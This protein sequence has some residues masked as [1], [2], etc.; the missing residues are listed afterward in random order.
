MDRR[1]KK[2]IA[3]YLRQQEQIAS[4]AISKLDMRNWFDLWHTHVDWKSKAT[5]ARP[6]V[7]RL[8]YR[9]L[10]Q[11]EERAAIRSDPI[12]LWATLCEDTG[13]NAIY[14]HSENPNGSPYPY[15]FDGVLWDV[16]APHE[17]QGVVEHTHE[18]GC[19]RYETQVVYLIRKRAQ[20]SAQPDRREDAAPG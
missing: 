16:Q 4:A 20:Q 13:Q 2:R 9:L 6:Q 17:L 7:A 12:Q 8:T 14:V 10:L 19:A 3:R 5:R 11:A 1:F 15:P 18:L